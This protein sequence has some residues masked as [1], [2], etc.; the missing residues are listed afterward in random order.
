VTTS[1][2][3]GGAGFIGFA[4]AR[5]LARDPDHHVVVVDN[6]VRGARDAMFVELC[7]RPNV[8]AIELDLASPDAAG[9]LPEQ[10][11]DFVFHLA[12]LNGTQNFYERPYEVMRH[13]TL[14]LFALVERYVTSR[15]VTG[16]FVYAGSSEEYAATVTRFGWNVPTAEDVPLCI[17]EPHNARWSYATSKLHGE[18]LTCT[19]CKQFG[20]PFTA[21]R[22]HNVYGP[23]MGDKHV[24][25]D[26]I[27]RMVRGRYELHGYEDTRSF[28]FVDDAVDATLRLARAPAAIDQIVNVGSDREISMSELGE[29]MM[30]IAGVSAPIAKHPS[31]KGSVRRR[32]PDLGKLRALIGFEPT[33]SLERGLDETMTWYRA[34]LT[35]A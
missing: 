27:A 9:R 12:A 33:W 30:R 31:P 21:I 19:A 29:L 28:L 15:K 18:V 10:T 4:V 25:P 20:I 16:R 24:I 7:A 5:A 1:L 23:R 32:V 34:Q 8:T 26:F 13:S 22:Y 35:V 14:P 17:D 11:F 3:T 6:F 2:V